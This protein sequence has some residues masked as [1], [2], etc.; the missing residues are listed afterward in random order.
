MTLFLVLAAAMTAAV[1]V[2]L[3]VPLWRHA[4]GTQRRW[5]G[6]LAVAT[7]IPA[8]GVGTY[9]AVSTWQWDAQARAEIAV[10]S[11]RRMAADAERDLGPGDDVDGWRSLAEFYMN[12]QDFEGAARAFGRA[13]ALTGS[14]DVSL[15]ISYAEALALQDPR[16]LSGQAGELLD[17]ALRMQPDN[18]RAL[19]YGGLAAYSAARW[20]V[21]E[22]RW[23][24]LLTLDPP[25]PLA[26]LLEERLT[27]IRGQSGQTPRADAPALLRPPPAAGTATAGGAAAEE[28]SAA[29]P[30][31]LPL[32]I[33]L[34][35][36]LEA[37]IR[38][39]AV[40]YVIVRSAQTGPPM[41]VRRVAANELPVSLVID[42]GDLMLPGQRL[43]DLSGALNITARISQTGEVSAN[44]GD[45]YGEVSAAV[46]EGARIV[47]DRVVP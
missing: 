44:S 43:A 10:D 24:R 11:L 27:E 34:A 20:P 32:S 39:R 5:V 9:L 1:L 19:W 17:E 42:D 28:G 16:N 29:E 35:T 25:A 26:R 22:E 36:G 14:Q 37:L 2:L 41:A 33:S 46:G 23:G 38:E 31:R 18:P 6:V 13:H 12:L 21:A 47:I 7:L 30:G 45:L 8:A 40:L 3:I 4:A 15:A